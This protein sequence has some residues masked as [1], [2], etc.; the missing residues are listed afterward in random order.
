MKTHTYHLLRVVLTLGASQLALTFV[1]CR[2]CTGVVT[3]VTA[4]FRGPPQLSASSALQQHSLDFFSH[5]ITAEPGLLPELQA[6]GLLDLIV[7]PAFFPI[8]I[9]EAAATP[10]IEDSLKLE[11]IIKEEMEEVSVSISG[12]Q[13]TSKGGCHSAVS[14]NLKR[15]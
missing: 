1:V 14:C 5:L 3:A 6:L 2:L 9:R 12:S 10:D 4:C 8:P 11:L 7:S 13:Q 15:Q